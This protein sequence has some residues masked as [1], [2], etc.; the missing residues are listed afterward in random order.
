MKDILSFYYKEHNY[1]E[2]RLRTLPFT[3]QIA[4]CSKVKRPSRLLRKCSTS[5][6]PKTLS[7]IFLIETINEPT[8]QAKNM[9]AI[10]MDVPFMM[11][12]L[13]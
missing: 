11:E 10:K 9:V 5:M 4:V 3:I 12:G 7:T 13:V 2:E 8:E 1:R 6:L